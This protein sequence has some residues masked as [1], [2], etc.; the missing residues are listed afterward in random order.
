MNNHTLNE[1][2]L[3]IITGFLIKRFEPY[4]VVL[5]GSAVQ[6]KLR[7]DSDIDLAF[8]SDLTFSEYDI[9]MSAREL[10]D[11]LGR[12]VDLIDMDKASTVFKAQ[13]IGKGKV[14]FSSD[15]RRRMIF[16]M[17]TYKEYAM[18]NEERQGILERFKERRLNHAK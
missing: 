2:Q 6:G 18:L 16:A 15:V 3:N 13:V 14:I 8:L 7:P 5:F 4:L 17:D 11:I 1:D 10:S 9:F 12:D